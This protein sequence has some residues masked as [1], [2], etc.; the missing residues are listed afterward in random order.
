MTAEVQKLISRIIQLTAPGPIS[1]K[2]TTRKVRAL[3]GHNISDE[4]LQGEIGTIA[5]YHGRP[6]LFDR[7]K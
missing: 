5:A 1:V 3:S 2:V 4:D 6:I 7:A